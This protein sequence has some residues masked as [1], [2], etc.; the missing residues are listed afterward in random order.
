[1][2]SQKG[3][4]FLAS[5]FKGT[6]EEKK[7]RYALSKKIAATFLEHHIS[8]F[9][10]ILYNEALIDF[11]PKIQLEDRCKLLMPMNTDF[12]CQSRGMVLLKIEG[13]NTSSGLQHYFDI[14]QKNHIPIYDLFPEDLEAQI[15]NLAKTLPQ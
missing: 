14:C 15:I 2:N 9:A 7:Y 1:M 5:P 4:Y 11:F 6:K 10:P 12:L 13:W 8:L 3:Y